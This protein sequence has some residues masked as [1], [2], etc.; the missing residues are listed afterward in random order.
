MQLTDSI[1]YIK[2]VGPKKAEELAKETPDSSSA[3]PF[4]PIWYTFTPVTRAA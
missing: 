1:K 4:S 2:G 3:S